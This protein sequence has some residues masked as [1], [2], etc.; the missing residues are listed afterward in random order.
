M[1]NTGLEILPETETKL[2]LAKWL[3]LAPSRVVLLKN[4][5][6]PLKKYLCSNRVGSSENSSQKK[7]LV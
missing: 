4:G 7:Q 6:T 1:D 3:V 5:E 2:V